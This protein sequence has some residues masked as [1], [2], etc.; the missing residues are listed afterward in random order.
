MTNL[1]TAPVEVLCDGREDARAQVLTPRDVPLGGIRAMTVRRTL[2]QRARSFIGAWCF[3]DHYG[4]DDVSVTG[5]MDVAPHPHTGLQTVSWLFSGEIE[6]RDSLGTH[7]LVRPGEM[8]LM[9]AGYGICHSEV[10]TPSTT[11]LHGVQL[12]TLLPAD[13]RDTAPRFDHHVPE[14]TELPDAEARVFMGSLAGADSP[15]ST[16]SPLVGAELRLRPGAVVEL[17]LDRTFEH[18]YLIDSGAVEVDDAP[19]APGELLYVPPGRS[20]VRL[21]A[22]GTDDVLLLL[23]GGEPLGEQIVIWWNFIGST[24]DEVVEARRRWQTEIGAEPDRAT[25]AGEGAAPDVPGT[26]G[27]PGHDRH[28]GP[29]G[30][31]FGAVQGYDGDP[32]PAPPLPGTRLLPRG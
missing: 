29:G 27:A 15:V 28:F 17:D 2:P 31:R 16:F 1:E 10:S 14:V 13:S 7:E 11:I 6:H 20:G 12:W 19:V 8:N 26:S 4:P 32:L 24:H 23:I 3:C 5:G 9:T 25:S 22:T 18:G 21:R 30:G